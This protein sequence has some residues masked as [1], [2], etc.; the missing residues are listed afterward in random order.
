MAV[1]VVLACAVAGC[2]GDESPGAAD[3]PPGATESAAAP[4]TSGMVPGPQPTD[5]ASPGDPATGDTD[6]Q[7]APDATGSGGVTEGDGSEVIPQPQGTAPPRL[8]E[9]YGDAPAAEPLAEVPADGSASGELV[10]GFPVGVI[11]LVPD[12]TV[13]SS[14]VSAEGSR[15]Q[16]SLEA[17]VAVSPEEV[18]GHYRAR[19]VAG[20]FA[21]DPVPAVA[22]TSAA[23][24]S[25]SADALVVSS[26]TSGDETV[27][28]VTGVLVA[29]G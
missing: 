1:A 29:Q 8:D 5:E 4:G 22:G 13:T 10:D 20:G 24:F 23:A 7:P 14:A 15:V 16:V 17:T 21:E 27:F 25:R 26:R 12:A 9:L 18:L 3:Q 11:D 6:A 2:S 19:F 28:S